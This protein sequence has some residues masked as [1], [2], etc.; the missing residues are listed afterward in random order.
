MAQ[1]GRAIIIDNIEEAACN[2]INID[3]LVEFMPEYI[4]R[5]DLGNK[6]IGGDGVQVFVFGLSP[7]ERRPVAFKIARER[8][9]RVS[10]NRMANGYHFAPEIDKAG[11]SIS[12]RL[13]Q[14]ATEEIMR[15]IAM[16]QW[17]I[18]NEM[19][20]G[21]CVGGVMHLTELSGSRLD[22]RI[23]GLFPDYQELSSRFCD[24]IKD[25]VIEFISRHGK[26]D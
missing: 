4:S 10:V 25:D 15:R 9:A 20:I 8:D 24:P 16:A 21:L 19:K 17:R 2:C 6:I 22:R 14:P 5:L 3:E 7:S 1:R 11:R 18:Q 26:G 23:I 13:P 12:G